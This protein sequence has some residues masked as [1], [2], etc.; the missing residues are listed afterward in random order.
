MQNWTSVEDGPSLFPEHQLLHLAEQGLLTGLPSIDPL[1]H[2]LFSNHP[3]T[4]R[5]A[6]V[7][8]GIHLWLRCLPPWA[9][10][11]THRSV[12]L[13]RRHE[14]PSLKKDITTGAVLDVVHQIRVRWRAMTEVTITVNSMLV[15]FV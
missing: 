9:T 1:P 15:S 8:D 7:G 2:L 6:E 13:A 14:L 4:S 12:V 5:N 3:V 11:L 10:N